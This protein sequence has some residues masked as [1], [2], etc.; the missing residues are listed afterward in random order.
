MCIPT[1]ASLHTKTRTTR[2]W[3]IEPEHTN[4]DATISH[5]AT[6]EV[7]VD[8]EIGSGSGGHESASAS[9]AISVSATFCGSTNIPV[10]AD[11]HMACGDDIFEDPYDSD[12]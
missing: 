1:C 9:A 11:A 6:L 2:K 12:A 4:L 5:L 8:V 3:D 7:D 10:P